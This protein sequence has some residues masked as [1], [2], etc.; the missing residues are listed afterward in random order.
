MLVQSAWTL[1]KELFQ[2]HHTPCGDCF[3]LFLCFH[4]YVKWHAWSSKVY[5]IV[6]VIILQDL[7]SD[8]LSRLTFSLQFIHPLLPTNT[9]CT[10][11]PQELFICPEE[12]HPCPHIY[13][14]LESIFRSW[15][16]FHLGLHH[17]L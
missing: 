17:H 8:P 2:V 3:S 10:F 7:A 14:A 13:T 12:W 1:P 15:V 5:P 6:W 4:K 9:S 16:A 11:L